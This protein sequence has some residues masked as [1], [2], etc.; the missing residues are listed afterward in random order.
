MD[1]WI[2][3]D[4][5]FANDILRNRTSRKKARVLVPLPELMNKVS[6]IVNVGPARFGGPA[7]LGLLLKHVVLFV[8]WR[9]GSWNTTVLNW[10]GSKI[11]VSRESVLPCVGKNLFRE[12][13]QI[14]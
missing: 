3:G 5:V 12:K 1:S 14:S 8:V 4:A 9:S 13:N 6:S 2:L 7:I 10:G 11:W